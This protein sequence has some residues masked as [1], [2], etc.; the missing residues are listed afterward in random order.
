MFGLKT[1]LAYHFTETWGLVMAQYG[2]KLEV[3]KD[4][5]EFATLAEYPNPDVRAG[6]SGCLVAVD[7]NQL[8]LAGGGLPSPSNRAFMFNKRF[9]GGW[10]ELP[11]ME[12]G[13][14]GHSCGVAK[15]GRSTKIVVA[16]G[17]N[18]LRGHFLNSVE[19]FSPQSGS[20]RQGKYF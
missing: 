5:R 16:G 15:V 10:T 19:I 18:A 4:G 20:W 13:R 6:S 9:K 7:D 12:T 1:N 11:R 8:F 2:Q 14:Y 3:T 17:R